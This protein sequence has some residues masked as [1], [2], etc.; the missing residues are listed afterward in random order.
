MIGK[1]YGSTTYDDA[2]NAKI[3]QIQ[4]AKGWTRSQTIRAL[5]LAGAE[6]FERDESAKARILSGCTQIDPAFFEAQV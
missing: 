2:T 6:A 1:N 3:E 5:T 4:K